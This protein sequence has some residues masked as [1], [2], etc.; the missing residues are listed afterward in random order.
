MPVRRSRR[1]LA[2]ALGAGTALCACA[3]VASARP[4]GAAPVPR[5]DTMI[6]KSAPIP[7]VARAHWIRSGPTSATTSSTKR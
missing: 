1:L 3:G 2:L 4:A 6:R 7:V 5:A